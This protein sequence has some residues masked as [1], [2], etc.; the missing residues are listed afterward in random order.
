MSLIRLKQIN[1]GELSDYIDAQFSGE[2]ASLNDLINYNAVFTSGVSGNLDT[3][4]SSFSYVSGVI[5]GV[6]GQNDYLEDQF[7]DLSGLV[8]TYDDRIN[9]ISG[10]LEN[11]SGVVDDVY[12]TA[13]GAQSGLADLSVSV[14]II[15]GDLNDL[16]SHVNAVSGNAQDISGVLQ[17]QITE[18]SGVA[19]SSVAISSP[20][21]GDIAYYNGSSWQ[22]LS[23][24]TSGQFLTTNGVAQ[25]PNWSSPI[26]RRIDVLRPQNNEPP[27]TNFATLD[28]RN[29]HPVLDFDTTTQEAAIF[30]SRIPDGVDLTNGLVVF[31]QWA[32]TSATTGTIGWDVSFERIVDSGIDIDSDSW[33]TAQT[34]TATTVSG[35]SGITKVTSVTISQVDLPFGLTAGDMIRIRIRRDV[36]SDTATGDAELLQVEIKTP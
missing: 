34:I 7:N 26:N 23:A 13:Y 31:V 33:S 32:A 29:S 17:D 19:G 16:I 14:S 1:T 9:I 21:Q 36:A 22:A 3:L 15:S 28:T 20:S 18:L 25:N 5:E 10:D 4:Y 35:T 8:G 27:T 2:F 6:S 12:L 30:S 24:G 11:L